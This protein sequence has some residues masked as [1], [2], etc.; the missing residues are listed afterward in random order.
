MRAYKTE[1][2]E[3]ALEIGA[4]KFGQFRLKS[5]RISPYFFNSGVFNTGYAVAKLGRYYAAAARE[6]GIDCDMLFGPAYKGIPLVT[7]TAAAL[8]E[9]HGLDLPFCFNRKEIKDHG[10]G[11][12]I[13]GAAMGGRVLI[14]DDVITAGTAIRE[15]VDVIR[16]AGGQP[17]G[18]LIALDRQERGTGEASAVQEVEKN[19]GVKVTSIINLGDLVE[20]LQGSDEFSRHL[21]LVA[22]YRERYGVQA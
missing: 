16:A 14:V 3:L 5:G 1:F 6:S 9:H 2:I 8:A 13:V 20:H 22:D 11:G 15:S 7:L 18:V 4:L 12:L 21:P 17:T 19:Y 10:E